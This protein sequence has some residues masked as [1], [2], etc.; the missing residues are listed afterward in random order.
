[1][2]DE[3]NSRSDGEDSFSLGGSQASLVRGDASTPSQAGF[4]ILKGSVSPAPLSDPTH[5]GGESNL[6]ILLR[7]KTRQNFTDVSLLQIRRDL[8]RAWRSMLSMHVGDALDAVEK[9]ELQL[10]DLPPAVSRRF[11]A[12]TQ[13]FRAVGLV[14]QDDSLGALAIA[15]SR[16]TE[17]EAS[18][19]Y[20]AA[21]TLCRLGFWQL[22]KFDL[23]HSLPRHQPRTLWSRSCAIAAMLDLS[24]EAAVALD[25][26]Q[27]C[28]AK[29]LA[30]D[31]SNIADAALNGAGGLAAFPTCLTA[32]LLYEEG[33]LDE[34]EAMLRDRLPSISAEGSI[35]CVL[36][37]YLVLTRVAKQRG[38]YDFAAL[39]LREA[40][41]LGERRVWPRLVAACLAE[42]ASLLLEAGRVK[43]AHLVGDY[44]DR[45][46]ET[47]KARSGY[48]GSEIM[49]YRT[50]TRWRVSWAEAPSSEAVAALRRLYHHSIEMKDL[51]AGSRLAVELA[52]M[53][54]VIGESEEADALFF[55]TIKAGAAAGLY[56]IFLE[57]AAGLGI[58]L[59]RAYSRVET[60]GSKDREVL[61]FVGSLLSR[62]DARH[63]DGRSGKP[64]RRFGDTL[65]AREH[66]IL[67]MISQ[68]RSNK[69]IAR[70]LNISPETVKSHVKRI[71]LKLAVNTRTEAVSRA[72][73][74]GLL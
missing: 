12:A 23:F 44:L 33:C 36:R 11:R 7:C 15:L 46:A 65:S 53:L 37:A 13:L 59:R 1:M 45:Y 29:R 38:Q 58:L 4:G 10:D 39:L 64:S 31:A 47:H 70:P 71:F 66:D 49:R 63:T 8:V 20:H 6:D 18:Q 35:E 17:N 32:Q 60:P 43:E 21:S 16:L 61:P 68:G 3:F 41:A 48:S 74:L 55:Q 19:D 69:S 22:G 57:G 67:K 9:I 42:R 40:Q 24:I 54:A 52:Q 26:L 62:W 28:A 50:L 51:Y 27:L 30:S 2:D 34:A 72:G 5:Y 25:H 73:S 14:F 56:Q